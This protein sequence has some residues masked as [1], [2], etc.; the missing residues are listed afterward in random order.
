MTVYNV[1]KIFDKGFTM[2]DVI[3][4]RTEYRNIEQLQEEA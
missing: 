1:T 3:F 2:N 4:V